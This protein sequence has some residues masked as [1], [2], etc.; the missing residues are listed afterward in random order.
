MIASR[1]HCRWFDAIR[2]VRL[3]SQRSWDGSCGSD[4]KGVFF[5]ALKNVQFHTLLLLYFYW[6][7]M[8]SKFYDCITPAL[9]L[10]WCYQICTFRIAALVKR[11]LRQSVKMHCQKL[12]K[13]GGQLWL[14]TVHCVYRFENYYCSCPKPYECNKHMWEGQ[15]SNMRTHWTRTVPKKLPKVAIF[16]VFF[17]GLKACPETALNFAQPPETLHKV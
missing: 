8:K 6:F 1:Q 3:E 13:V 12:P 14:H 5:E 7:L 10:V 9:S 16:D 17:G 2:F 11:Q 4:L 15:V